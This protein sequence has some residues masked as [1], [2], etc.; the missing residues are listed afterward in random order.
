MNNATLGASGSLSSGTTD[1]IRFE[2]TSPNA[3]KGTFNVLVRRG[4]DTTAKPIVLESF[5]T[6]NVVE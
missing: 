1:N 4:D 3:A 5:N 6:L 2:I